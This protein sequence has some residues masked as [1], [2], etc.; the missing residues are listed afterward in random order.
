MLLSVTVRHSDVTVTRVGSTEQGHRYLSEKGCQQWCA[1]SPPR[2]RTVF[3]RVDGGLLEGVYLERVLFCWRPLAAGR[4]PQVASGALRRPG[5][6]VRAPLAV[7]LN[8]V[9]A[10]YRNNRM[11]TSG[12]LLID[13]TRG[14]AKFTVSYTGIGDWQVQRPGCLLRAR[15]AVFVSTSAAHVPQP[16]ADTCCRPHGQCCT[17]PSLVAA[18]MSRL[19]C[20]HAVIQLTRAAHTP[21]PARVSVVLSR[22][23]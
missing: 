8:H 12:W 16:V 22:F 13:R 21:W 10:T 14:M 9:H 15:F 18:Y 20:V 5:D 4:H 23:P 7:V 17:L 6:L 2:P 3:Q 1:A 11:S 19:G